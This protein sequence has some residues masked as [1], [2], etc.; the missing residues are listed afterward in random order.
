MFIF[1]I[2]LR[3]LVDCGSLSNAGLGGCYLNDLSKFQWSL[4][5]VHNRI[6][7]K[8]LGLDE[9]IIV[10]AAV[11]AFFSQSCS[12]VFKTDQSLFLFR[13]LSQLKLNML[14]HLTV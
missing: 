5:K 9:V 14:A 12:F 2:H 6:L 13:Q 8:E 4:V 3:N 1:R 11:F 7:L 10:I